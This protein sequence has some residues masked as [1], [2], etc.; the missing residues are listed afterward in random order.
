MATYNTV[1]KK[2]NAT[3]NGWDSVLPIT[4]AENV[5]IN[6]EGDTLA[7]H[8]AENATL[9]D[10]TNTNAYVFNTGKNITLQDGKLYTFIV[11]K[12]PTGNITIKIDNN[13]TLPLINIKTGMQLGAGKLRMWQ[14]FQ[15]WYSVGGSCFFLRASSSGNAVAGDV[16]AGKT[17]SNDD[18][19]DLVG[20]IPD[21]SFPD[22]VEGLVMAL[23]ALGSGD[24]YVTLNPPTGYYK[25][26]IRP[27]GYYRLVS[28]HSPDFIPAN[29][30]TGKSIFGVAGTAIDGAGMAKQ[31]S[32][33][34]Y[35]NG[36]TVS[37]SGL[38][39][40]P[41][42]IIVRI[43]AYSNSIFYF[44]TSSPSSFGCYYGNGVGVSGIFTPS[45]SST[46]FSITVHSAATNEYAYWYCYG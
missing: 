38:A 16:L 30:L 36:T 39:F 41:K 42:I 20:T 31:A 18:D 23:N 15:A 27:N 2:R 12:T 5:L 3:N 45:V 32:G 44:W 25:Q 46:G 13:V 19:T 35:A 34:V 43:Y 28:P 21:R 7:T 40:Q 4:T 1:I 29:I 17:F 10:T 26:G 6:A 8:L 22:G 33:A 24:G 11:G 9:V 37:V 14:L